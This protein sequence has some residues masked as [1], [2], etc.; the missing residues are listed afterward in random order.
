MPA[1]FAR[2]EN[3][4]LRNK[5]LRDYDRARRDEVQKKDRPYKDIPLQDL[6]KFAAFLDFVLTPTGHTK[7]RRTAIQQSA[8]RKEQPIAKR[9]VPRD[10]TK[11][12]NRTRHG[13][14]MG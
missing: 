1:P 3:T 5:L 7:R 12:F 13:P 10:L 9:F 11:N 6:K 14:S 8:P 4:E 2:S